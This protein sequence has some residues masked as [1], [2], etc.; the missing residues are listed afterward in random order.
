MDPTQLEAIHRQL[1]HLRSVSDRLAAT[2]R[3]APGRS[4][5]WQGLARDFYEA[6]VRE[7]ARQLTL[8]EESLALAIAHTERAIAGAIDG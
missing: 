4:T 2:D 3:I 5:F 6:G 7:L 1:L 8:V